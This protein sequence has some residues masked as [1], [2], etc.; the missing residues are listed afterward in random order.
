MIMKH[1]EGVEVYAKMARALSPYVDAFLAETMSSYEE[2]IQVVDAVNEL[3]TT[4]TNIKPLM[5]SFTLDGKGNF[6]SEESV[7]DGI[8]R[9]LDHVKKCNHVELLAILFNCSEPEAI[10]MAL[11]RIRDSSKLQ[12]LLKDHGIILGAYAN[13]LTPVDPDW[14]MESSEGAQPFREDLSPKDYHDKFVSM[15]V[16]DLNVQIVGGCCGITPEHIAYM[17]SKL[18]STS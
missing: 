3:S 2:C 15:W 17:S 7:V 12:Q 11:E 10:T 6:R 9:L 1:G 16:Q 18:K 4:S 5:M 14:T 13:R 8:Q